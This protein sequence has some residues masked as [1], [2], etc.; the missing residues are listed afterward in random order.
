MLMLTWLTGYA[1]ISPKG[2][3]P[4]PKEGFNTAI[5]VGPLVGG[6]LNFIYLVLFIF[7]LGA[8]SG[9]H[10]NPT[11]T[12][13]TFFARLCSFPRAVLYLSFQT[14]GAALG[15]LLL[16]AAYGTRDFQ[17][18]GCWLY[19]EFVPTGDA[20]VLEFMACLILLVFAFGV[21]LDP[22]QKQSVG[23]KLGP[24]LVGFALAGLSFGTGYSRYGHG[25][26]SLNPGRCFGSFVGSSFPEYHWIHWIADVC[27]CAV[28]AVFY[29]IVPPWST[30]SV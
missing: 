10:L 27:A 4:R 8:V 25:G 19:P 23:P 28:H 1:S 3:P 2:L 30:R 5:F 6:L 9:A 16:R 7:S 13:A 29:H 11:I 12:V 18:G 15:G 14:A 24:F 21:G 17:V 22:R 20:F 26:A